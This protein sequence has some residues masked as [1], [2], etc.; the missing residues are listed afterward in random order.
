M[1]QNKTSLPLAVYILGFAIFAQGTSELM[2]AGLL[3]G[4]SRG[5]HVSIPHAGLLISGFAVGMLVGAPV[6]ALATSRWNH[7]RALLA[8]IGVFVLCHAVGALA[9][10]YAILLVTRIVS[11]FVYA[12]FWAVAGATV[13]DLV[14][15]EVRGRAL[16]VLAGGLT[17]ATV[18][19]LPGGTLIAQHLG[20]RAAFWVV[21]VLSGLAVPGVVL[22]IPRQ[23][24]G[25]ATE[26]LRAVVD[27]PL[28]S[29]FGTTALATGGVLATFSYLSPLLTHSAGIGLDWVPGVLALYGLGALSGITLGARTAD[30]WP[31]RTLCAGISGLVVVS[32]GIALAARSP[33]GAVVLVA[34]LGFFGF[35]TNPT[36]SSR[37][38][39][40]VPTAPSLVAALNVSAFNVGIT[41]G[42]WL[43]GLA[44]ERHLGYPAVAW[45]G[46]ALAGAGLISVVRPVGSARLFST[47][48]QPCKETP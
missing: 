16:A 6:L 12:G 4:I 43:G 47:R 20:W 15:R 7:R 35:V 45:V 13:V 27:G 29:A 25:R 22:T 2:L 9:P 31:R 48:T 40:L 24:G 26:R 34:L 30:R 28:L 32:A 23:Q 17:V 19:G 36:L 18:V 14:D 37:P 41:V 8:F 33:F 10:N 42:P 38:F 39:S 46:A 1:G 11:A 5:L 3:P 21:A 44:I